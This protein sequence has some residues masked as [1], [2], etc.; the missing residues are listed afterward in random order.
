ME[1][2]EGLDEKTVHRNGSG[3]YLQGCTYLVSMLARFPTPR[4][5]LEALTHLVELGRLIRLDDERLLQI[6]S[7]Y[8]RLNELDTFF[9]LLK[10]YP[11]FVSSRVGFLQIHHWLR[12]TGTADLFEDVDFLLGPH[13]D[14]KL[15]LMA[16]LMK[17]RLV[18]ELEVL[19]AV[20]QS[21]GTKVP[22]EIA[23]KILEYTVSILA[24]A[25]HKI[26]YDTDHSER[27]RKLRD[28][29]QALFIAV[30][31]R[32][33]R[34]WP[35][36]IEGVQKGTEDLCLDHPEGPS[37]RF[38]SFRCHLCEVLDAWRDTPE[39]V[40]YITELLNVDKK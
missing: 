4:S 16:A 7:Y 3:L 38:P 34:T 23:D 11:R 40:D 5:I 21:V 12:D 13:F 28:H 33:T 30:H 20:V 36:I 35:F 39:A 1:N 9:N 18:R 25:K 26:L 15:A 14:T 24:V 17:I 8:L 27:I 37:P 32:T 29:I 6:A 31:K 2:I 19:H 22:A 10:R